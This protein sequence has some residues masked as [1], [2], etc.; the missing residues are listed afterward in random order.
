VTAA[1]FAG[2]VVVV[3]GAGGGIGSRTALRFAQLG[4]TVVISDR[5]VSK[6]RD[7][8]DEMLAQGYEPLAVEADVGDEAQVAA[9]VD[10]TVRAHGRLDV[11][12]NAAATLGAAREVSDVSEDDFLTVLRT[13]LLG[14]FFTIKHALPVMKAHGHGAVVNVAS[15]SGLVAHP[16]ASTYVV[17]KH[18]LI[19]LTR[20]V[21]AEVAPHGIR[22]NAVCPG[23]T[24]TPQFRE[25]ARRIA[26]AAPDSYIDAHASAQIPLGRLALP[27]EQARVICFLASDDARYVSGAVWIVDGGLMAAMPDIAA[28][29][30]ARTQ[31]VGPEI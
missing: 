15:I 21:A 14:A 24:D 30:A 18:A 19:G 22:V 5:E 9:L 25:T 4:G 27:E 11:V 31:L 23:S 10:E 6:L 28:A 17:S 8:R 7:T 13:N 29:T 2:R 20:A 26:P 12:V 16:A 3:T 1:Q